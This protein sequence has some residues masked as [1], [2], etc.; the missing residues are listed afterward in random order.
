MEALTHSS[1]SPALTVTSTH[2]FSHFR[3]AVS[4]S[5]VPLQLS[6]RWHGDFSGRIRSLAF[7]DI[8]VSEIAA[9]SHIVERTPALISRSDHPYFKLTLQLEGASLLVQDDRETVLE[10]GDFAIYDTSRP[11]SLVF[12]QDFRV[13]VLMFPRQL[14]DLP[15]ALV[16]DI[17][18]V[19][20]GKRDGLGAAIAPFIE[21]LAHNM[22][23]SGPHMS[24]RLAN[25]ALDLVSTLL[26]SELDVER[27]SEDPHRSLMQQI[28]NFIEAHLGS[29]ELGPTSIAAAHFISTRHLHALFRNQNTT[30]ST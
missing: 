23:H 12:D 7:D 6:R 18:A 5:F 22:S 11:Y 13:V 14:L 19:R 16:E 17:T 10:A 26:S 8:H 30:V 24:M 27:L 25:N 9:S 29:H 21:K 4:Q 15:P 28:H 1:H 2:D 20:F 3:T